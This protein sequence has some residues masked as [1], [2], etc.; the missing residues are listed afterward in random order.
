[1]RT[2]FLIAFTLVVGFV[3]GWV[4]HPA[5]KPASPGTPAPAPTLPRA[6]TEAMPAPPTVN[7]PVAGAS[8]AARNELYRNRA[9]T[10]RWLRRSG[11]HTLFQVLA[12]DGFSPAFAK[13]LELA[14][15]EMARL[16][17][18]V[19][20]TKRELDTARL[21]LA[22]SRTSEDGKTLIVDVPAVDVPTS[23]AAYDRLLETLRSTL[24]PERYDVFS[25][26]GGEVFERGFDQ[27]GLNNVRYE[28]VLQPVFS[29]GST[30][31]HYEY[32][33]HHLDAMGA[34]K[35]WNGNTVS[36]ADIEKNDPILAHFLQSKLSATD[37]R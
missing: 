4:A 20:G 9:E 28:L 19:L 6:P 34:G 11:A 27:Y 3:L 13:V 5:A 1:M 23:R 37:A 31:P 29:V 2:T 15:D 26:L 14:P 22:T 30:A 18:V 35:G 21:A 16:N 17:G 7:A 32:K 36:M 24:G 33:R 12:H 10:V 25:E 8:V